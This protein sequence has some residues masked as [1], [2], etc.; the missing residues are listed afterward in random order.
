MND[1]MAEL[2]GTTGPQAKGH[3]SSGGEDSPTNT[4][5]ATSATNP[6]SLV[7]LED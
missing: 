5:Q 7:T 3:G 4:T 2:S 6:V 1:T